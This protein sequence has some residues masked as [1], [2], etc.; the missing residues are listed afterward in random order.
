MQIWPSS[1]I[2]HLDASFENPCDMPEEPY[3]LLAGENLQPID[4]LYRSGP[5]IDI[6][7]VCCVLAEQKRTSS[8][9]S[10]LL[11]GEQVAKD[12][13]HSLPELETLVRIEDDGLHGKRSRGKLIKNQ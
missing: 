11:L 9:Q 6:G 10:R 4:M 7:L 5:V 1:S 2:L 8:R 13:F 3:P 12:I